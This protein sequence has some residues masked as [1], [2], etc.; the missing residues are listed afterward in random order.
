[1]P[2]STRQPQANPSFLQF[3]AHRAVPPELALVS[4][5]QAPKTPEKHQD[6]FGYLTSS[7]RPSFTP[8]AHGAGMQV[9]DL[10]GREYLDLTG[11]TLNLVWGHSHPEIL[12]AVTD[13]AARLAFVSS[14]FASEPFLQ[15]SRE[16]VAA[17]PPEL[18]AAHLKLTNGSDATETAIKMARI[19]TR[20]QVIVA[21]PNA[22]HGET[23]S[24]LS[25]SSRY[26]GRH[27]L[28]GSLADQVF[29]RE[30]TLAS[31]IEAVERHPE[32]AAVILDPAG[33]SNGIFEPNT[34]ADGLRQLRATCDRLGVLLIFDEVQT[35]FYLGR[36]LFAA[37]A[38]GVAP[39]ILCLGKGLAAGFP[40]AA[41]LCREPLKRVVGY[42]QGE[43]TAGGQ[44]P[45]CAAALAGLALH[46]RE[47]GRIARNLTGFAQVETLGRLRPEVAVRRIGFIA[48]FGPRDH[49]HRE[50]WVERV[51]REALDAGMILR[52]TNQ[53]R[54]LLIKPSVLIEPT[55]TSRVVD[56]LAHIIDMVDRSLRTALPMTLEQAQRFNLG[57]V[58]K[59]VRTHP[60]ADYVQRLLAPLGQ[61]RAYYRSAAEQEALSRRLLDIGVPVVPVFCRGSK[62]V[63][64]YFQSGVTLDHHLARLNQADIAE[65]NGL[66]L[67]H[68]QALESAHDA[69]LLI[70]D[71]WGGNAL[72]DR[73]GGLHLIDFELGLEGAPPKVLYAFE[74]TFALLQLLCAVGPDDILQDLSRRFGPALVRR[75]GDLALRIWGSVKFF[76]TD[77]QKPLSPSSYDSACYQRVIAAL[78]PH[79][80]L[81][82]APDWKQLARRH[83]RKEVLA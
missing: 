40:L 80:N 72:V 71:R 15:L 53:D 62:A 31:L 28:T 7:M 29:A 58:V 18:T 33:V 1:M 78:D 32:A 64:Y 83:Q 12:K 55:M 20:R 77:P 57:L 11:Q 82:Q 46:R 8:L 37:K 34:I 65:I 47:A 14:R 74:E 70:G 26:S 42:N 23:T 69:G 54:D 51:Y 81:A 50:T 17:A 10:D 61:A 79:L 43:F 2:K 45:A 66:V 56:R 24:T 25:L 6:D 67:Q 19:H 38:F 36:A 60:Q 22:W 4:S 76:Y 21:L 68:Q 49:R 3:S 13:Q 48:A 44:P 39:D 27:G 5:E 16:L 73:S 52:K 9:T 63:E 75:F 30:P 59:P 41:V 35:A